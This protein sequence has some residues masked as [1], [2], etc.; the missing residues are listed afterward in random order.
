LWAEDFTTAVAAANEFTFVKIPPQYSSVREKEILEEVETVV[1]Q[2]S[3]WSIL[4]AILLQIVAKKALK[5]S[6]SLF[7]KIQI[8]L[9]CA[10]SYKSF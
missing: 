3:I 4:M 8:V 2:F 6:W 7:C 1:Q 5:L 9:L 10:H